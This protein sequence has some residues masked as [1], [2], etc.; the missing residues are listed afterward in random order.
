MPEQ[1]E[2]ERK[3]EAERKQFRADDRK[4]EAEAKAAE[5]EEAKK[6][7]D[8]EKALKKKEEADEKEKAKEE[9][10]HAITVVDV[11]AFIGRVDSAKLQGVDRRLAGIRDMFEEL[12]EENFIAKVGYKGTE[13]FVFKK[14]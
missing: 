14:R 12:G 13:A 6:L 7:E 5:K 11:G 9:E 3:K 4:A 1:N 8:E 10:K 2:A